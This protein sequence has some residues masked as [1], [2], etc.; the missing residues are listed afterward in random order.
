MSY[1]DLH[2]H[3]LPGVDDGA[4]DICAALDHSLTLVEAGVS[5]VAVTPHIGHPLF[6]L[7]PL[8]VPHLTVLL[9]DAL[10]LE[11]IPLRLHPSGELRPGAAIGM[12][13][14]ELDAISLGPPGAR[15][16]LAEVPFSGIDDRFLAGCAAI[17]S[18]GLGIVIAH[19]ERA[20]GLL[21]HGLEL[22]SAELAAGAVLQVNA[23]S[24]LG[25]HGPVV[26]DTAER[27]VRSGLA[28]VIGSDGHPGTREHTL[29]DGFRAAVEAGASPGRARRLT[30]TNPRF[31]LHHGV[32]SAPGGSRPWRATAERR[33]SAVRSATARLGR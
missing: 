20:D 21:P 32:P 1:V 29:E 19:P 15:W 16:V 6:P 17:R 14:E 3:L 7:D 18:Y 4:R 2:M 30:R 10:D 27:L 11:R 23:C 26:K 5:D 8:D 9:Q 31:L 25:H 22:L 12:T 33:I 28:Y 13:E 24:L